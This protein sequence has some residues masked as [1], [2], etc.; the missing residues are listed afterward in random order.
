MMVAYLATAMSGW[1]SPPNQKGAAALWCGRI[2]DRTR[3]PMAMAATESR[4]RA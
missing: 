2:G 4:R 3:C 1:V